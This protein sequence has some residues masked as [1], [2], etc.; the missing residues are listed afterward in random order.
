VESDAGDPTVSVITAAFEP[1]PR[2]LIAAYES[3]RGQ[4]PSWEWLV[5]F[6]GPDQALPPSIDGDP[7]IAVDHNATRVGAA[8]SRNRALAR[9]RARFVLS[10]DA[11]DV[12]LPDA[13]RVLCRALGERDLAFAF[14]GS[15]ELL[16][17]GVVHSTPYDTFRPGLVPSGQVE[18]AWEREDAPAIRGGAVMWRRE[19]L[20]AY[21]GWAALLGSED[22]AVLLAASVRHP[23]VYVGRDVLMQRRH[24]GQ[25]SETAAYREARALEWRFA[26]ERAASLRALEA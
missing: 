23:S 9:S 24:D 5:Q 22:T 11:D 8:I 15:V 19:Y 3:L 12:L 13:L 7:R 17:D 18:R 2:H 10:L 25:L 4:E 14:G 6:D 20:L 16:P 1:D 26:R 21:G